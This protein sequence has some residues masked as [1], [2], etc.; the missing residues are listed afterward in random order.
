MGAVEITDKKKYT[1]E[2]YFA[3][4]EKA[5][6]RNE[7]HDGEILAMSGGSGKHS[8]LSM[9]IGFI[10]TNAFLKQGCHIFSSDIKIE[11]AK[12]NQYVYPDVAVVCGEINYVQEREHIIDNPNIIVEVLSPST[13]GYDRGQKFIKYWSLNS[14]KEYVLISQNHK[15]VEVFSRKEEKI[16]QMA[17][18]SEGQ[19]VKFANLEV[20][21]PLDNIYEGILA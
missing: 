9:R 5:L 12:L 10:F 21:F 7:F 14:L 15:Q 3:L 13:E 4:E 20:E 17:S 6:E 8:L 1:K 11:L 16:W 2:A 19:M 18:Y